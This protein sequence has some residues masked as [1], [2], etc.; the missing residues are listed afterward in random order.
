[1]TSLINRSRINILV[2][3]TSLI[4]R[5]RINTLV[6]LENFAPQEKYQLHRYCKNQ[7][8]HVNVSVMEDRP[9]LNCITYDLSLPGR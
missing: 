2:S 8:T 1:M 4:N 3:L 7:T 6:S 9:S 5:S